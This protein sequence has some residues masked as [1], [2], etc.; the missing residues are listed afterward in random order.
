M[1]NTLPGS[2]S[3]LPDSEAPQSQPIS[4]CYGGLME[5]SG[6]VEG[7]R[8][9]TSDKQDT[10]KKSAVPVSVEQKGKRLS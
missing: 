3:E 4:H 1:H 7:E 5:N 10:G 8:E 9:R 6:G 2:V